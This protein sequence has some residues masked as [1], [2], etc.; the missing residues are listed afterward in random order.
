MITRAKL[1]SVLQNLPK[2]RSMLAGNPAFIPNSYESIATATVATTGQNVTFSSI[3]STYKSLQI[4]MRVL[5]ND[6]SVVGLRFNGDSTSNYNWH[7]LSG[8]GSSA[9]ASTAFNY[10]FANSIFAITQGTTT[11]DWPVGIID[12][13]DYE[14]STKNKTI[15]SFGGYDLNG[16]G[17]VRISSGLWMSTDTITDIE[18]RPQTGNGF[19]V[20]STFALYG[21]KGA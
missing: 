2:F 14:S 21:I 19:Y 8:D 6:A 1:S 15:R 16:S 20:G 10:T 11:T 13:H 4:R 5:G 18:I 12:I 9:S 17:Q 3:P 7:G